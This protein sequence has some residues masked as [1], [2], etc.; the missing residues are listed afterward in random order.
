MDEVGTEMLPCLHI[1]YILDAAVTD[2]TAV[3]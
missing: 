1:L 3:S 2:Q